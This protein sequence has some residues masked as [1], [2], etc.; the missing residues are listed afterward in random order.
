MKLQ[1]MGTA[2]AEAFPAIFCH[3][4]AC[5]RARELGGKN[6]RLRS[7]LMVNDTV[8][9][10]FC[11]DAAVLATQLGLDLGSVTDLF[12]THSHGDHFDVQ[13]LFMRRVPVFAH[14]GD[15][16][17]VPPLRVH[18]NE[19]GVQLM[20]GYIKQ[21]VPYQEFLEVHPLAYFEPH[22][23]KNGLQFT[24]LPANHKPDEK[25]GIYY[26]T[27]GDR[28]I[29]YAHDTGVFPDD[30]M[31][32]LKT[33]SLD[34]LSLDCCYGRRSNRNGHMG[35][36]E[37]REMVAAL[38]EAGALKDDA[39]VVINHFSHN[40]CQLHEELEAEVKDDGFVVAYDGMIVNL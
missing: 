23:A 24:Y 11:P 36:P 21:D 39:I 33:K 1:Y 40:C 19:A 10:D 17:N 38:R 14:L 16:Q 9:I 12:V 4:D 35:M 7:G 30:T 34:F 2:A 27:D 28:Q 6:I 8:M 37:N 15:D 31:A 32:F 26:V 18:V 22:T 3:C 20:E 13:D 25:A 5:R 29:V